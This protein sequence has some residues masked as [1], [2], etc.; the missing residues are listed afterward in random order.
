M[1][2]HALLISSAV[3]FSPAL[4]RSTPSAMRPALNVRMDP[5]TKSGKSRYGDDGTRLK[6]ANTIDDV[7]KSLGGGLFSGFKWGTEVEVGDPAVLAKK[8]GAKKANKKKI[9]GD[10]MG[11]DRGLG[12]NNAYRNTESARLGTVDEGQRIR[13]ERLEAYI[14]S[15]EEGADKTFGKIIS[16]SLILTL[17][18]LLLGVIAYYGVDGLIGAGTNYG[19]R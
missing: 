4:Q 9:F 14:T 12:G 13:K 17:I 11:S 8:K 6:G 10:G 19:N 16:G 18:A 2:M 1:S 3:A 7:D 5:W 15:T